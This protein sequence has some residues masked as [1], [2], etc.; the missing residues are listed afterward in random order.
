[1]QKVFLNLLFLSFF[2]VS[3]NNNSRESVPADIK[4]DTGLKKDTISVFPVTDYLLGQLKLIENLP[5][6]PLRINEQQ[7]SI[8]SVW[9][10]REDV[11]NFAKPFLK[12][13]IDSASLNKYYEGSSFLDQ[14]L[15]AVTF[16]YT[17]LPGTP[18]SINLK[19]INVY[20]KPQTN[21]VDRIYLVKEDGGAQQQLTWKSGKWFSI[22]T[23]KGT[24]VQEE[25]VKWNFDERNSDE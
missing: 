16:S 8:D 10:K 13:F 20:I 14:T 4:A 22:R 7:G 5:V 18:D 11:K 15:N 6:T 2:F 1:M 24:N 21:E 17:L 3:C 19:E 12:P 25:K 23:I 9:I